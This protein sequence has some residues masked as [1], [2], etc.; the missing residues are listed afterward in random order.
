M[1][2]LIHSRADLIEAFLEASILTAM[3]VCGIEIQIYVVHLSRCVHFS[4]VLIK[5][6][7]N[8]KHLPS[9]GTFQFTIFIYFFLLLLNRNGWPLFQT[10]VY[11]IYKSENLC[12][13]LFIQ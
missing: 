6:K 1:Y 8:G 4:T 12:Y 10:E 5:K 13:S 11:H 3:T 7:L 2:D 9:K